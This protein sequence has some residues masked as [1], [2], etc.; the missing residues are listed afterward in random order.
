VRW[1][2]TGGAIAV[3]VGGCGSGGSG[4]RTTSAASARP[5]ASPE[6]HGCGSG[7]PAGSTTLTPSI[8]GH[9][10]VVVVHVPPSYTGASRTPLVL[11]L[12]GSRST[13]A[14][15]ERFSGM[16][17]SADA[18]GFL[19]AY[20]QGLIAAPEGYDWNIP[21][22]PLFGGGRVPEHAADDVQFLS[23]LP[24]SLGHRYC[25]D[26]DRVYVT[27][28]SGGA[29]M[30]SQLACDGSAT[31]AAVAPV[32]GLRRPQPCHLTRA[33]AVLAFHG[34]ADPVD[35]YDGHGQVYWTYPVPHAARLWAEAD[36]CTTLTQSTRTGSGGAEAGFARYSGCPGGVT[37][38]LYTL[39]GE[40]HEWPGGPPLPAS[41]IAVLGPQSDAVDADAV[42]WEF[43]AAHPRPPLARM[44]PPSTS[45]PTPAPI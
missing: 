35:P 3:L 16:D 40:G 27:G 10:R 15:Q 8:G 44:A 34:T 28:F 29:R 32:S 21:G 25:V 38:E 18:D 19:V 37:V 20:P 6:P 24:G 26:P 39:V 13:A 11:N 2:A 22:T 31:F 36:G 33:I 42:M 30:A 43:F 1:L 45:S 17:A 5:I 7:A 23:A 4:S 14:A 12:H 9:P 41:V